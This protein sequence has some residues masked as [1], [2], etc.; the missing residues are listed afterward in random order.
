MQ[1]LDYIILESRAL[2]LF[3]FHKWQK[4]GL[5]K[6]CANAPLKEEREGV[7][8]ELNLSDHT[9][10]P[11]CGSPQNWATAQSST[12]PQKC[13]ESQVCDLKF[14]GSH[15]SGHKKGRINFYRVFYLTPVYPEYYHFNVINIKN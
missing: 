7:A 11:P 10:L 13:N 15:I 5:E 14:S 2:S 6:Q 3:L 12:A 4:E 1:A 8:I 9:W